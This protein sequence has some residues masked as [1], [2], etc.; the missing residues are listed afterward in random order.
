MG[1]ENRQEKL[2]GGCEREGA[3][4]TGTDR[5]GCQKS[6]LTTRRNETEGDIEIEG[7]VMGRGAK[8]CF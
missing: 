4:K 8:I 1:G 7:R 3:E 5:G 2:R 6:G